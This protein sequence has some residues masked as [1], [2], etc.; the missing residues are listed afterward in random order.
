MDVVVQDGAV[1]DD[2]DGVE[3]LIAFIATIKVVALDADELVRQPGY[4]V[5]SHESWV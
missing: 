1:S 5:A 2:D 4:R 3:H